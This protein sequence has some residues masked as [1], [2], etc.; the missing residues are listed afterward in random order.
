[1]PEA[2]VAHVQTCAGSQHD[3]CDLFTVAMPASR[4]T[5]EQAANAARRDAQAELAEF[6]GDA[7]EGP[8]RIPVFGPANRPRAPDTGIWPS[9]GESRRP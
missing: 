4:V 9:L 3:A 6:E 8:A 1:V 7:L 5:R 2:I